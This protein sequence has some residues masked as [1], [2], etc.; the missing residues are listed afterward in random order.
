MP[1]FLK[2]CNNC[3]RLVALDI[4]ECPDCKSSSFSEVDVSPTFLEGDNEESDNSN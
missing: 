4:Q 1:T 2:M 3:Y